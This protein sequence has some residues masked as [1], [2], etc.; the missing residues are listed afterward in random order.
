VLQIHQS[1]NHDFKWISF[2]MSIFGNTGLGYININIHSLKPVLK[3]HLHDH[4]IQQWFTDIENSS[5]G[6]FYSIFKFEFGFE[7]YLSRISVKRTRP[8]SV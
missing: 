7:K 3:E 8:F 5:R 4:F 1:G 2:V 6:E